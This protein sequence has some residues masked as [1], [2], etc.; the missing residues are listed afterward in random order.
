MVIDSRGFGVITGEL[1]APQFARRSSRSTHI[2]VL[3]LKGIEGT[4]CFGPRLLVARL[5]GLIFIQA[6]E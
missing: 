1:M 2:E 5:F 6:M 3:E 4:S